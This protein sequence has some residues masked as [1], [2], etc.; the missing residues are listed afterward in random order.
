MITLGILILMTIIILIIGGLIL[1]IG[2]SI[3]AIVFADIIVALFIIWW[4]FT[5]KSKKK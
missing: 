4:L 2:G 5:R 3:F 1:A